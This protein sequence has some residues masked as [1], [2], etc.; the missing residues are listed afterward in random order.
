MITIKLKVTIKK[1]Q[2]GNYLLF[3]YMDQS[4]GVWK[5][6]NQSLQS[7]DLHPIIKSKRVVKTAMEVMTH[8]RT[9]A[10]ELTEDEASPYLEDEFISLPESTS[11]LIGSAGSGP[12]VLNSDNLSENA[13]TSILQGLVSQMMV[14]QQDFQRT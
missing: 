11:S 7:L 6:V 9:I 12:S 8:Q 10:V 3:R 14:A 4:D 1:T 13:S 2:E 5:T